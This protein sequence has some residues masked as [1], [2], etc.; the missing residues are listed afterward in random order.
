MVPVT[1]GIARIIMEDG[2][3]IAIA[4]QAAKEGFNNLRQSALQKVANLKSISKSVPLSFSA[5]F[6]R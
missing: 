5:T 1:D 3:S 6:S 2:N 4:D